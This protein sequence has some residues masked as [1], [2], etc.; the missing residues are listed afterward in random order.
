MARQNQSTTALNH[1]L[2]TWQRHFNA[3]IIRDRLRFIQRH[4]EIDSHKDSFSSDVCVVN[5]LLGHNK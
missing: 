3:A 1:R 4:V 5:S 2:D